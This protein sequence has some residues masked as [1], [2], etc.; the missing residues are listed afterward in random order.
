MY[1][2]HSC[3]VTDIGDQH[4]GLTVANNYFYIIIYITDRSAFIYGARRQ[5]VDR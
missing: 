4:A 2:T 5:L 1:L 3:T